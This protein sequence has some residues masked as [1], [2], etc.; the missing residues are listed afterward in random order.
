[1]RSGFVAVIGAPNVGKSSMINYLVGAKVNI[2][3]PRPQTTRDRI[4]AVA[5]W[6]EDDAQVV[7]MDTPGIFEPR[8]ALDRYM[9]SNAVSAVSEIEIL[10]FMIDASVGFGRMDKRAWDKVSKASAPK[11]ILINKTDLIADKEKLLAMISSVNKYTGV[12]EIFPVSVAAGDNMDALKKR[13]LEMLPEGPPYYPEDMLTDKDKRY[14]IEEMV[15][16]TIMHR[17]FEELPYSVAIMVNEMEDKYVEVSIICERE[18]QKG[19]LIGK[20]G[21]MVKTIGEESRKKVEDFFGRT[22]FL[23]IKVKVIKNWRRDEKILKRM[24]YYG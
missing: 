20:G 5:H 11:I 10:V 14:M 24:G 9:V 18:S 7:F 21:S 16:E 13:M 2:V 3:S 4:R 15:R 6:L 22:V 8:I 23:N 19:I 1:M 12:D 17:V